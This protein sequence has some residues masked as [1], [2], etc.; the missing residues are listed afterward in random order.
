MITLTHSGVLSSD[1]RLA[2]IGTGLNAGRVV[3]GLLSAAVK[4]GKISV[5]RST[6]RVTGTTV[7]YVGSAEMFDEIRNK[8]LAR[9]GAIAR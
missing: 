3:S 1:I 4:D 2:F 8:A 6:G 7:F 9:A 5:E